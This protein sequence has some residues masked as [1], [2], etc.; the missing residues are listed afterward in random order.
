MSS[1]KITNIVVKETEGLLICGGDLKQ[2]T[3]QKRLQLTILLHMS[4]T[5]S[6]KIWEGYR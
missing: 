4:N 5:L 6:Y 1:K 3:E 2:S